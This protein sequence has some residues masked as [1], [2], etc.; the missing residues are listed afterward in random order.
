[1]SHLLGNELRQRL[2]ELLIATTK[3]PN[4]STRFLLFSGRRTALKGL[5]VDC[6][7]VRKK[8][9]DQN[10]TVNKVGDNVTQEDRLSKKSEVL[11]D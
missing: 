3:E 11:P 10:S 2:G 4:S 1:M 5:V 7:R 6:R 9:E 8:C